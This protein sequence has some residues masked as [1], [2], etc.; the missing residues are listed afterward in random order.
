MQIAGQMFHNEA[1]SALKR[2]QS[3]AGP[4]EASHGCGLLVEF[5]QRSRSG[6]PLTEPRCLQCPNRDMAA[7]H[8]IRAVPVPLSRRQ[9]PAKPSSRRPYAFMGRSQPKRFYCSLWSYSDIICSLQLSNSVVVMKENKRI[10]EL[11]E[12]QTAA[13]RC[14]LPCCILWLPLTVPCP[15][16]HVLRDREAMSKSH[17]EWHVGRW[18][19]NKPNGCR[20]PVV[21]NST[22][23]SSGRKQFFRSRGK[24][25]GDG[26]G[27]LRT[28]GTCRVLC[29]SKKPTSDC[30]TGQGEKDRG[31]PSRASG[32]W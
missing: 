24:W 30:R 22:A 26:G 7:L 12:L 32:F 4:Q 21:S 9:R 3:D 14:E 23:R 13:W 27:T 18:D 16:A 25:P 17:S 19:L 2:A 15:V 20:K 29:G 8:S 10:P 5:S 31:S 6:R 28:A 11:L 1:A